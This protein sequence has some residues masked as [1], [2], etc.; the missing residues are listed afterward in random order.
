M[1][2]LSFSLPVLALLSF[3]RSSRARTAIGRRPPIL[4]RRSSSPRSMLELNRRDSVL[5]SRSGSA[6]RRRGVASRSLPAFAQQLPIFER[7]QFLSRVVG[8]R[9]VADAVRA[10]LA[11]DHYGS[12]LV[13]TREMAAE[14]LYYLRDSRPALCLAVGTDAHRPIRDDAALSRR[15]PSPC[16][17]FRLSAARH[18]LLKSFGQ[19]TNARHRSA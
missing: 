15:R 3:R 14:L 8:W 17:S 11:E 9:D 6:S 7:L 5:P 19:V 12:I 10:K 4:P 1:L 16:C 2:L 18:S 13:D